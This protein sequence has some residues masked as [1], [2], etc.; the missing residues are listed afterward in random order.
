M[1]KDY[2][3]E[4]IKNYLLKELTNLVPGSRIE[5][6]QKSLKENI[7]IKLS[8]NQENK[9]ILKIE[10]KNKNQITLNCFIE[11]DNRCDIGLEK[12]LENNE[13]IKINLLKNITT[14]LKKHEFLPSENIL[15]IKSRKQVI[16]QE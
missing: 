5:E 1:K 2:K 14:S 3:I 11:K 9:I 8:K 12:N 4:S 10:K 7:Q 13:K 16:L 6:I 15:Q